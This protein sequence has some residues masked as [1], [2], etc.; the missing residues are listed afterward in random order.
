MLSSLLYFSTM[1]NDH[2]D[3]Q[4]SEMVSLFRKKNLEIGITGAMVYSC[5][6]VVQY[7]EG[8][9]SNVVKLMKS[10]SQDPRH[11]ISISICEEKKSRVFKDWTM[12][13]KVSTPD[14]YKAFKNSLG[15]SK[16]ENIILKFIETN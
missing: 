14:Q 3:I 5:R 11:I 6:N 8:E 2:S 13:Y 4:L 15:I 9:K 10:I 1:I 12:G 16:V 7:I